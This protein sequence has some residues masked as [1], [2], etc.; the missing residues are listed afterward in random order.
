M[1]DNPAAAFPLNAG[2]RVIER[3]DGHGHVVGVG[4]EQ[5]PGVQ[6]D[7]DVPRPED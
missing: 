2:D 6:C 4:V 7:P 1:G 5:P 3:L